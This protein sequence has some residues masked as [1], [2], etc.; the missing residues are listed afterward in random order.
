MVVLIFWW[1]SLSSC[2]F[3]PKIPEHMFAQTLIFWLFGLRNGKEARENEP[4]KTCQTRPMPVKFEVLSDFLEFLGFFFEC[5]LFIGVEKFGKFAKKIC[6]N[7]LNA[8]QIFRVRIFQPQCTWLFSYV[9]CPSC[10]E[11]IQRRYLWRHRLN[12]TRLFWLF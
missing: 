3:A 9:Q 1:W 5:P 6:S 7:F 10:R 8:C 12:R 4:I 11:W 2:P